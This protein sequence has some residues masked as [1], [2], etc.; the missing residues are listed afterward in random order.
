MNTI[1]AAPTPVVIPKWLRLILYPFAWIFLR[2][3]FAFW[4]IQKQI[5]EIR[6][7]QAFNKELA[8]RKDQ[9]NLVL[10]IKALVYDFQ[11]IGRRSKFI[12]KEIKTNEQMREHILYWYGE[13]LE[14]FNLT[15]H[16][17]LKLKSRGTSRNS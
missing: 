9:K 15:I 1:Q 14:K 17:D 6:R 7:K 8:L 10:K 3:V 13:D 4:W 16:N 12:P 11:D 2:L 5:L